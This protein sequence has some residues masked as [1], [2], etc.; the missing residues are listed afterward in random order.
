[1]QTNSIE[2]SLRD[3]RILGV[4]LLL[5]LIHGFLYVFLLPPWQHYDEPG[6]FE[7]AWLLA[8]RP[9]RPEPSDYDQQMRK[10]VATSMIEHG[11]FKDLDFTPDLNATDE[12]IWIG[13][14]QLE[15]KPL[16]YWTVSLPLRLF[17]TSSIATQLYLARI[18]SLLL[19]LLTLIAA[20]GVAREITPSNSPMRWVLP[21]S[22]VL[23]PGYTELM[24]AVNND[25]GAVAAFSLFLWS[26]I[27]LLIKGFSWKRAI[28]ST[29][30]VLL[31][32]FTKSTV[33][34][35]T[36]LFALTLLLLVFKSLPGKATWVALAAAGFI[37]IGIA[38]T[39][40]GTLN[41]Y[42]TRYD[43]SANRQEHELATFGEFAFSLHPNPAI[44]TASMFQLIPSKTIEAIRG[45]T[46]TFGAWVWSDKPATA[47]IILTFPDNEKHTLRI[48]T[49]QQPV[50]YALQANVSPEAWRL[51]L[52]LQASAE[53]QDD[54]VNVF[55]DGTVLVNGTFP[56]DQQPEFID[57]S[58]N[59]GTWDNRDFQNLMRNASAETGYLLSR[60]WLLD[61]DRRLLGVNVPAIL[62]SLTDFQG[63]SWYYSGTSETLF[64]TFWGKFGWGHVQLIGSKPYRVLA[65]FTLL[66]LAITA[67][68]LWVNRKEYQQRTMIL[69]LATIFFIWFQTLVRGISS[70]Y[71]YFFIPSARYAFA[72]FIPT[73]FILSLGWAQMPKL[74]SGI[75][76]E[77][78]RIPLFLYIGML[79]CLDIWAIISIITFYST[80]S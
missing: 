67:I 41:W 13:I 35:A 63:A 77:Y 53:D 3:R 18:V 8:N 55:F 6:H 64:R 30:L 66:S 38:F 7:Y 59:S 27:L 80:H 5:G 56:I 68:S 47:R 72:A 44:K 60:Q 12:P 28:S 79:I 61:L 69:L 34:V 70:L 24:T 50:F 26:A 36:I 39:W 40:N 62:S 37:G 29:F 11:F 4:I 1:M 45:Q 21:L 54:T 9:G 73:A 71:G 16:Y 33:Y 75:L 46:V 14:S 22:L 31:C 32:L 48:Q 74:L 42:P 10:E 51:Y 20:W 17:H 76:K 23:M 58:L 65:I 15:D 19:Y 49:Q 57:G 78:S 52:S 2:S 25:V 43:S